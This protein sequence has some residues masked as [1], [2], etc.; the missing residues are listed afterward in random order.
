M[1]DSEESWTSSAINEELRK[2]LKNSKSMQVPG[3][4]SQACIATNMPPKT[5][6]SFDGD[7]G[8]NLAGL[9]NG[10]SIVLNGNAGRFVGN[11]MRFVDN[12]SQSR[13][14]CAANVGACLDELSSITAKNP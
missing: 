12:C 14:S 4:A 3:L 5:N 13:Q 6:I 8:D 11:G 9:N 2:K 1:G 10:S 7:A